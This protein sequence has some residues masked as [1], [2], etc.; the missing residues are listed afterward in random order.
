MTQ[1]AAP[2]PIADR[3]P[4]D[5]RAIER[6][7]SALWKQATGSE[8]GESKTVTR[9]NALNL[10]AC[11]QQDNA[12]TI[13][14]VFSE[15]ISYMPHRALLVARKQGDEHLDAWVQAHCRLPAPGR[16]QVCCE[17][18]TIEAVGA[19]E[20]RVPGTVLPLLVPDVPVVLWWPRGEPFDDP[21]FAK[22]RPMA[23]RVVVDSTTFARPVGGLR[24]LAA[25]AEEGVFVSDL[26]WSRLT[27]WRELLAQ[28]FDAPVMV[29]YLDDVQGVELTHE[30]GGEG[31]TEHNQALLLIGWL[32]TRL[33]WQVPEAAS[34][35]QFTLR[36]GDG[37]DVAVRMAQAAAIADALDRLAQCSIVTAGAR[38]SVARDSAPDSAVARAEVPGH[39][40]LQR[41]VRLEQQTEARL[42]AEELRMLGRDGVFERALRLTVQLEV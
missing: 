6:E 9:V 30:P 17:Q 12:E 8:Q 3:T 21:L 33:G 32:A 16:P 36:R 15:L 10:V 27:P 35:D 31:S 7:L 42:L 26:A 13:T 4:V 23:D 5:V 39:P 40:T 22:M 29:P 20:S 18:I 1:L 37:K 38:F 24:R 41:V 19:A 14:G 2:T 25:L 28:F 11:V 34:G